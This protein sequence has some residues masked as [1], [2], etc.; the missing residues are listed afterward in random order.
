MK[1]EHGL[2]RTGAEAGTPEWDSPELC[3]IEEAAALLNCCRLTVRRR[4]TDGTIRFVE[5]ILGKRKLVRADV[6]RTRSGTARKR[7]RA[8]RPR[9]LFDRATIDQVEGSGRGHARRSA[10]HLLDVVSDLAAAG[11]AT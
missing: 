6:L 9:E 3:T 2:S 8:G 7:G 11:K 1:N 5:N 10:N 4:V